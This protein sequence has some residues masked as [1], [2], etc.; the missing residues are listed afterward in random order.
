MRSLHSRVVVNFDGLTHL[1]S[2][3]HLGAKT[4]HIFRGCGPHRNWGNL[5]NISLLLDLWHLIFRVWIIRS[6]LPVENTSSIG[7]Y[8][9][10]AGGARSLPTVVSIASSWSRCFKPS[11]ECARRLVADAALGHELSNVLSRWRAC[12]KRLWESLGDLAVCHE[13]VHTDL[14]KRWTRRWIACQYPRNNIPGLIGNWHMI[15]E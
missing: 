10:L 13:W 3:C 15:W 12:K 4:L 11:W 2:R 14:L 5:L 9:I 8:D 1:A 6:A 7:E